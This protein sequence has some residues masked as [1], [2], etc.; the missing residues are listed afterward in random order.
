[1]QGKFYAKKSTDSV[2]YPSHVVLF[3]LPESLSLWLQGWSSVEQA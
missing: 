2:E 1:M 3:Y